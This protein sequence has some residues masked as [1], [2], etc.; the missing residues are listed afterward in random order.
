MAAAGTVKLY[1]YS[2]NE[3]NGKTP[4]P[5][6]RLVAVYDAKETPTA[7]TYPDPAKRDWSRDYGMVRKDEIGQVPY[8]GIGHLWLLADDMERARKLLLDKL[9]QLRA[10]ELRE[11]EQHLH[12]HNQHIIALG[13]YADYPDFMSEGDRV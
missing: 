3:Y 6:L 11:M 13:G 9:M 2:N 12:R 8:S 5:T 1:L 10:R 4:D 7:Y